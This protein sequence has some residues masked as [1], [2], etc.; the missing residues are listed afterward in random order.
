MQKFLLS[1]LVFL[2][3]D[4]FLWKMFILSR[5]FATQYFFSATSFINS[6]LNW[7]WNVI[8][9]IFIKTICVSSLVII[10]ITTEKHFHPTTTTTYFQ[11][12]ILSV[13]FP[14][15]TSSPE[16]LF[17]RILVSSHTELNVIPQSE[18]KTNIPSL[19]H[20]VLK[21]KSIKLHSTALHT[22]TMPAIRMS[23]RTK[24]RN[25]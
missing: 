14:F 22:W 7:L 13:C 10:I 6:I 16:V 3:F 23:G 11:Q 20:I 1:T 15:H 24:V 12:A 18:A 25:V 9:E 19:A 21:L 5:F 2:F 8:W 4:H 17:C